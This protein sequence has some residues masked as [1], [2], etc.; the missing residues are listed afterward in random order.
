MTLKGFTR[1]FKPLEI[2]SEVEVE[3]IHKGTLDVLWGTGLRF[4]HE[5]ALKLFQKEGCKV[6]HGNRRVRFPPGLVEEC[7]RKCPSSFRVKARDPKNDIIVGANT[8]YMGTFPGMQTVD[9]N[10][11]QARPPT[12]QEFYQA[13]AL[14]DGLENLHY[15][16]NYSPWFGYEGVPPVMCLP[17]GFAARTRNSS[18][19]QKEGY[20]KESEIFTI[21]MSKA[22]G[23]ELI[24]STM[25]SPPLTYYSEAIES[26]RRGL[27][28]DFPVFLTSG[29]MMGATAPATIAGSM[30]TSNAEVIAGLVLA[31]LIKPGARVAVQHFVFSQ[32]MRSGSPIFGG[33]ESALHL[34]KFNQYFRT[35]GIPVSNLTP[36]VTYSK[37]IDFQCGYEKAVGLTMSALSG[38]NIACFHGSVFGEI[39]FHPL[40]AILDDDIAG[41]IGRFLRGGEVNDETLA[42][43][44]ISQVGPIPGHF[45]NTGHTRKWWKVEQFFPKAVDR[46]TYPEWLN[47]GKKGCLDY[48]KER[49]DEIVATHRPT[50]L[51]D[52]QDAEIEGILTEA[53]K[54]YKDKGLISDEETRMYETIK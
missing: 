12:K 9:L 45:L 7:L 41:M 18:K 46:L 3:A 23:A 52:N 2:L 32:N 11:W 39:T 6:D 14:L 50:P 34:V 51:P 5:G 37:M 49:M 27:E 28:A 38:A 31:Q 4:E 1:E 21:A 13:V 8:L 30:L 35:L 33:I 36:G 20:S 22:V 15:I 19:V 29:A 47:V 26:L 10:T 42:I 53:R 17:E 54:Y 16:H 25:A 43:D 40:Q 48:A 44:L 24:C